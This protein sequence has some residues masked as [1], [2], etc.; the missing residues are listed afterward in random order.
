MKVRQL[1]LSFLFSSLTLGSILFVAPQAFANEIQA[2]EPFNVVRA[3]GD[4]NIHIISDPG[5]YAVRLIGGEKESAEV[6]VRVLDNVLYVHRDPSKSDQEPL[7]EIYVDSLY[8]LDYTG[9]ANVFAG[10]LDSALLDVTV[11][12]QGTVSLAGKIGLRELSVQGSGKVD[13]DGIVSRELAVTLEGSAKVVLHGHA[14]L[15]T[16]DYT[17]SGEIIFPTVNSTELDINGSGSAYVELGG[18]V[19]KLNVKLNDSALFNGKSLVAQQ[20][21]IKTY[22]QSLAEI[23]VVGAQEALASDE[24]NIYYYQEPKFKANYMAEDGSVLYM[25]VLSTPVYPSIK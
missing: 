16:L 21:N 7:A 11:D 14:D 2:V 5:N 4:V 1:V 13:I 17:G 8:Q 9:D 19:N 23:H 22:Q 10:N 18:K 20:A 15:E 24:S 25:G 3:S 12:T 6:E